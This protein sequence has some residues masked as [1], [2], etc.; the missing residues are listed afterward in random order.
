VT[1]W[2]DT[3]I[4]NSSMLSHLFPLPIS[5]ML[6]NLQRVSIANLTR[7]CGEPYLGTTRYFPSR[8][9]AQQ[10]NKQ[11]SESK[12]PR[13]ASSTLTSEEAEAKKAIREAR[14]RFKSQYWAYS[15]KATRQ[16]RLNEW[17]ELGP[18]PLLEYRLTFGKH[19]GKKLDEV[20]LVYL[21]KYLIPRRHG[22]GPDM[23]CPIVGKAIDDYMKRHP[24][25]KSQAGRRKTVP[26][27]TD[28]VVK[29]EQ[30]IRTRIDSTTT[31][32]QTADV[33][34]AQP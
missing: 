21:V 4:P 15:N 17:N 32:P 7:P 30:I 10:V 3:A 22:V 27:T 34:S 2:L 28:A 16:R 13:T 20:P 5:A 9:L 1:G 23:E 14:L 8:T 12:E 24:G 11:V 29:K 26:T 19:C 25:V 6:R 33:E 18:P 31:S